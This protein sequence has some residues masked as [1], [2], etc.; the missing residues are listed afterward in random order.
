[1]GSSA[2]EKSLQS[3]HHAD[4]VRL[5]GD[6]AGKVRIWFE[7]DQLGDE[8]TIRGRIRPVLGGRF[9]IHEYETR[10]MGET[11]HGFAIHGYHIDRQR[12][13]SAWIDSFHTGTQLMFSTGLPLAA[14]HEVT[15]SYGGESDGQPWGWRTALAM[16]SP[17]HL[18]IAMYN[19][20]PQGEESLAVEFD[21]RRIHASRPL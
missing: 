8:S 17:D 7:P 3:G 1:M 14:L 16:E 9:V 20:T 12:H 19:V 6:W 5:A 11:Q 2:F 4:L 18:V 21:Y 13:E 10:S 15:G